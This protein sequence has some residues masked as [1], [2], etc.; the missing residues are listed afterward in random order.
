VSDTG[1][2]ISPDFLP[3]VFDRFRQAEGPVT[4]THGG[5]G[6]GL[7]IVRHLVDAHGGEIT[8]ESDGEGR[9]ATFTVSLP[10]ACPPEALAA[11]AACV[12]TPEPS[13]Q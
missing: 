1:Q 10:L 4:R 11:S 6:I 8:A 9:G 3:H 2:G 5:L 12:V 7:S 13:S